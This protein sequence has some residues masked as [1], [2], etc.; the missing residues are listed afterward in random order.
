MIAPNYRAMTEVAGADGLVKAADPQSTERLLVKR[1]WRF[2]EPVTLMKLRSELASVGVPP[3]AVTLSPGVHA[4]W[5]VPETEREFAERQQRIGAAQSRH[6][7]WE[8]ETLAR[9]KAKYEGTQ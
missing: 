8:R 7:A 6:E 2:N 9:L 5:Y 3:E 4:H 1:T